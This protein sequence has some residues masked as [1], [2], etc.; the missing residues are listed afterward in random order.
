MITIRKPDMVISIGNA[1][2]AEKLADE[3]GNPAYA[4]TE[5]TQSIKSIGV[6]N[7]KSSTQVWASGVLYE[8]SEQTS[9]AQ[10]TVSALELPHEW[11]KSMKGVETAEGV[12]ALMF[13]SIDDEGKEFAFGYTVFYK[14][15][16]KLFKWYPRCRLTEHNPSY[17]T[18]TETPDEKPQSY[19]VVAMPLNGI[20]SVT[21]DQCLLAEGDTAIEEDTF[22]EKVIYSKEQASALVPTP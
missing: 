9:D 10:L 19:T 12:D 13:E 21:Y 5:G 18:R 11:L 17:D 6:A 20:L 3:E 22:F 14:N 2:W 4:K 1:Y 8:V 7:N 16:K 15:G